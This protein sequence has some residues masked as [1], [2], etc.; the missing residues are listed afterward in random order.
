MPI[1]DVA[2]DPADLAARTD[3]FDDLIWPVLARYVP[4]FDEVKVVASWGG[5]Y[6]QHARSQCDRWCGK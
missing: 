4:Q 1:N 5:Q 2:V 3:E 6:D